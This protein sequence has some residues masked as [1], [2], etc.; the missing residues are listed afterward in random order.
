M[1]PTTKQ[2]KQTKKSGKDDVQPD[3]A[4]PAATTASSVHASPLGP[5]L[6]SPVKPAPPPPL[7]KR[8]DPKQARKASQKNKYKKAGKVFKSPKDI[9]GK[10][11]TGGIAELYVTEPAKPLFEAFTHHLVEEMKNDDDVFEESLV[12]NVYSKRHPDIEDD[13]VMSQNPSKGKDF[14][15][16]T[17]IRIY[18]DQNDNTHD[19]LKSWMETIKNMLTKISETCHKTKGWGL[20]TYNIVGDNTKEYLEPPTHA[21]LNRDIMH[22]IDALYPLYTPQQRVQHL[23]KQFFGEWKGAE[24]Y[25]LNWDPES[26]QSTAVII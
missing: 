26:E 20:D 1:A 19:N 15:F 12:H 6:V 23:S 8:V 4:P 21:L 18:Q 5:H 3:A 24:Q 11:Y 13:A 2:H 10:R 14:S 17:F 7:P 16:R 9:I 22:I 25:I